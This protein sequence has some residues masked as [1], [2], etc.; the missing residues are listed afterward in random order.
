MLLEL[1]HACGAARPAGSWG[2]MSSPSNRAGPMPHAWWTGNAVARW[3]SAQGGRRSLWCR[4]CTPIPR[5]PFWSV[6]ALGACALVRPW[7]IR[8]EASAPA[9]PPAPLARLIRQPA[10]RL[11]ETA[12]QSAS[13]HPLHERGMTPAQPV[14]TTSKRSSCGVDGSWAAGRL[15][16]RVRYTTTESAGVN[17][18]SHLWGEANRVA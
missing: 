18:I 10:G 16:A 8:Q 11:T 1:A 15:G 17:E 7:R 14:W 9:L 5:S 4:G 2:V 3:R 12:R 13:Q 6:T